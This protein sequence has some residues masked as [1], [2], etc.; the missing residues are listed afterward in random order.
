MRVGPVNWGKTTMLKPLEQIYHA[1]CNPVNDKYT[2]IVADKVKVIVL[3]YFKWSSE[4]ISWKDLLPLLE[5]EHVKLLFPK[6]QLAYDVCINKDISIFP[7]SKSKIEYVGKHSIR[8]E[9]K[10]KMIDVR[11]KIFEFFQRIPQEEQKSVTRY[12]TF[13][14]R[15]LHCRE[16]IKA[17]F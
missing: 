1:F 7:T 4:L 15:V 8:D 14:D 12:A 13:L 2:W 3:Q 11:W 10:T 5:G 16:T 9:R 6:N 17:A